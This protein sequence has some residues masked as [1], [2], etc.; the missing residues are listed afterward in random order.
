MRSQ[1]YDQLID[2]EL[3]RNLIFKYFVVTD[4]RNHFTVE[5]ILI[6]ILN[7]ELKN[8]NLKT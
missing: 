2:E 6:L 8:Q 7:E 4:M 3:N 5:C 1:G